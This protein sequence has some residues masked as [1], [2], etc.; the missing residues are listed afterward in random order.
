M[1]GTL[2]RIS[3]RTTRTALVLALLAAS[4]GRAIAQD[5]AATA[6]FAP[7]EFLSY[8]AV[9]GRFGHIGAGVLRVEGPVEMR[10]QQALQL[11]FDFIGKVGVFRVE[12]RTR[13]WVAAKGLA[14]LRFEREERS[15]L[16]SKKEEVEIF[17]EELRWEEAN[18]EEGETACE[19]PLDE[20]SFIY[21]IRTLPLRD[22]DVYTMT[23]HFDP[24]RNPV[25]LKVL[26]RERTRVPAGEFATVVVEMQVSDD[27]VSAMRF[28]LSDDEARL[29]VRIESSAPWVGSTRL[30]LQRVGREGSV[31]G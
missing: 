28:Y 9:S 3:R 21:F 8:R 2:A 30:L 5:T 16:G 6:P 25:T 20:L 7:G 24:S 4:G 17:P 18:G 10:G 22:G 11:S 15:P 29:P 19:H 27:R 13:S 26:R 12:D 23:H 1:D 14:T 31:G